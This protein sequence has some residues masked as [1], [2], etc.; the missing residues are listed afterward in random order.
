MALTHSTKRT[1]DYTIPTVGTGIMAWVLIKQKYRWEVLIIG[2]ILTFILLYVV[3]TQVTKKMYTSGPIEIPTGNGQVDPAVTENYD[4]TA[5]IQGIYNDTTCYFCLRNRDLYDQL[6]ALT[7]GQFVKAYNYWNSNYFSQTHATLP[8]QIAAQSN[9][10]DSLFGQQQQSL[11]ARF[12]K[13]G[14][15]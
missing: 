15:Q 12:A 10:W 5:L 6:I 14:L 8:Q 11:A 4:P 7:D 3:V 13:L 1:L 9:F 2:I